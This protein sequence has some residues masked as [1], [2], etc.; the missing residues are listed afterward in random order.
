MKLGTAICHINSSNLFQLT[1]LSLT[2]TL[3]Y[4]KRWIKE[5]VS[6]Q[7]FNKDKPAKQVK[8][9]R[10]MYNCTTVF[11]IVTQFNFKLG[12][13]LLNEVEYDVKDYAN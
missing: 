11:T 7:S 9:N 12:H 10:Y 8:G 4:L 3:L 5:Y 2:I 13:K 6:I 1:I